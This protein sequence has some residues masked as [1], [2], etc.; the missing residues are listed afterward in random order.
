[1]RKKR[2]SVQKTKV[3]LIIIMYNHASLLPIA[4]KKCKPET[5][6]FGKFTPHTSQH[7]SKEL[8]LVFFPS[9][10]NCIRAGGIHILNN[11]DD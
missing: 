10:T 7:V 6:V 11:K 1:M 9:F 8:V 2:N 3:M 4:F 5:F